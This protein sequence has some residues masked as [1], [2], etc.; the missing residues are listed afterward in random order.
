MSRLI[1]ADKLI[2]EMSEWYWDKE[3]QKAAEN[4]VSPMDL[5]THLA[6]TTV[7]EQPTVFNVDKVVKQLDNEADRS[8][9][10]FEEYADEIGK[11]AADRRYMERQIPKKPITY[12]GTNRADCPVCMKTVRGIGKPFGKYCA[13]CGQRL[14]WE[15]EPYVKNQLEESGQVEDGGVE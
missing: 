12:P 7:Q 11:S 3:K 1:D 5:F 10:Y 2:Q 4:D 9:T 14:K 13:G 8:S 6:I 15:A